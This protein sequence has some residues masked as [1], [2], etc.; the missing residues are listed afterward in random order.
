MGLGDRTHR[1]TLQQPSTSPTGYDD[2]GNIW[3]SLKL[4]TPGSSERLAAGA[5]TTIAQW[6]IETYYRSDV[7]AEWRLVDRDSGQVFQVASY[8][9]PTGAR[10]DL[11]LFCSE[12]Q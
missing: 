9:D 5:P 12:I 10:S 7:R 2:V 3:G 8:G 11:H 4:M 1:F 6:F